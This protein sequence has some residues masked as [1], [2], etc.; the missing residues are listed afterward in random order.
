MITTILLTAWSFLLPVEAADSIRTEV[1]DGKTYIIHQVE[2]KETLFGISRKYGVA[3]ILVVEANPGA[4]SGLEVGA[5]V[6]VPYTPNKSRKTREGTIH[7][8]GQKET[9]YSISRQYGVTVD[10]LKSWNN[11]SGNALSI[12]QDLLIKNKAQETKG[13]A[14]PKATTHT[15]AVGETIYGISRKYGVTIQQI[16]EWN[17]LASDELS[18]GQII[19]VATPS[20]QTLVGKDLT[21][22][23]TATM[24]PTTATTP[25]TPS[26]PTTT[27]SPNANTASV[28]QPVVEN[29]TTV[30]ESGIP[31]L[32]SVVGFDEVREA[33]MAMLL[34]GTEGNRKY[35]AHHRS[36]KAGTIIRVKNNATGKEVFARVIEALPSTE[37][38]DVVLKLSKSAFDKLGGDGRLQVE[39]TYF[40]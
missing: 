21:P 14:Q 3:L 11:L 4:G 10:D 23:P 16:K 26:I 19:F 12:G 20:A 2:Q 18:T 15:V 24:T 5:L 13:T 25:P 8:V 37:P 28:S 31:V 17:K 7:K 1:I 39:V 30:T 9:L 32:P 22:N 33:G 29:S 27:T 34:D 35:L 6:K 36:A 38:S 40:K